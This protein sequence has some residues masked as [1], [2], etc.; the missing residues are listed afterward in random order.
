MKKKMKDDY[1]GD[2]PTMQHVICNKMT[3][4]SSSFL[5]LLFRCSADEK[6]RRRLASA[7]DKF[8]LRLL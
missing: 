4:H 1:V 6:C 3:K 5:M 7:T 8:C 2:F